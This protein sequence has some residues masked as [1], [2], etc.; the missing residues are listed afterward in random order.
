[1]QN[2]PEGAKKFAEGRILEQE[3]IRKGEGLEDTRLIPQE[4]DSLT[5][6]EKSAW[7]NEGEEMNDQEA[8]EV[9]DQLEAEEIEAFNNF[10][11]EFKDENGNIGIEALAQKWDEA[12]NGFDPEILSLPQETINKIENLINGP[13]SKK[14]ESPSKSKEN[15]ANKPA[16]GKKKKPSADEQRGQVQKF[17]EPVGSID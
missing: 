2:N 10:V 13:N 14:P 7:I 15:K 9:Q 5:P 12:V 8:Q 11:A 17:F 4:W 16:Q 1:M 6:E 3:K